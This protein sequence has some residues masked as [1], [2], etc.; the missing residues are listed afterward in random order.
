MSDEARIEVRVRFPFWLRA[1][2]WLL[3]W[4]AVLSGRDPDPVKF[5]RLVLRHVKVEVI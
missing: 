3:A 2:M 4:A 5:E 1:Y